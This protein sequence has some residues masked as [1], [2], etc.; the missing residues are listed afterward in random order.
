MLSDYEKI[1]LKHAQ[2]QTSLLQFLLITTAAAV[3]DFGKQLLPEIE[4]IL[5]HAD[6]LDNETC[7]LIGDGA[8]PC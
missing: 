1:M 2:L 5:K 8:M 4:G 3:P 7:R 6:A